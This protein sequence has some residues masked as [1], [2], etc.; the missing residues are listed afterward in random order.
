MRHLSFILILSPQYIL[1]R[2]I[3]RTQWSHSIMKHQ[4]IY[5]KNKNYFLSSFIFHPLLVDINQLNSVMILVMHL[6][7]T[8]PSPSSASSLSSS[9]PHQYLQYPHNTH[10]YHQYPH[11]PPQNRPTA[12]GLAGWCPWAHWRACFKEAGI[13]CY[14]REYFR[15]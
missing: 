5:G 1:C 13:W 15:Q 3:V 12:G 6:P 7:R 4:L 8:I 14:C 9:A 2:T 10:Q 11:N